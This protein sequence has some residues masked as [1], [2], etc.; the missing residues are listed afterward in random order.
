M[1]ARGLFHSVF[2]TTWFC[3]GSNRPSWLWQGPKL[4]KQIRVGASEPALRR[5][6]NRAES[7]LCAFRGAPRGSLTASLSNGSSGS[8]SYTWSRLQRLKKAPC[9][10]P[11]HKC[12][13]LTRIFHELF[14]FPS[15]FAKSGLR[16]KAGIDK[17][18]LLRLRAGIQLR[19]TRRVGSSPKNRTAGFHTRCAPCF[20]PHVKALFQTG[21][22]HGIPR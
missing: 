5:A 19:A 9:A 4:P 2:L 12:W 11:W 21:N 7:S 3:L 6:L 14:R 17:R 8:L 20:P 10:S 13:V 1:R 18:H 16:S 15:A 22:T